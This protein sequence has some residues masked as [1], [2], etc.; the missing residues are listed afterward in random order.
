MTTPDTKG[1]VIVESVFEATELVRTEVADFGRPLLVEAT[2]VGEKELG[3]VG[4]ARIG[5]FHPFGFHWLV[6][7]PCAGTLG[8]PFA[9]TLLGECSG[10]SGFGDV[11]PLVD[12]LP[13][14]VGVGSEDGWT[15]DSFHREESI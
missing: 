6:S 9:A 7:M 11:H 8:L 14:W 2:F 10:H 4:L 1:N 5:F 3:C 13:V 12:G 15:V